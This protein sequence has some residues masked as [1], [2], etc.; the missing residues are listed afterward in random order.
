MIR[1]IIK[2]V[3]TTDGNDPWSFMNRRNPNG[4]FSFNWE[5]KNVYQLTTGPV[6]YNQTYVMQN[7]DREIEG[8]YFFDMLAKKQLRVVVDFSHG[9]SH[10]EVYCFLKL[11]DKE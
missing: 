1:C 7:S 2:V 10:Y 4:S 6:Q 3:I 8:W 11:K 9:N 5:F